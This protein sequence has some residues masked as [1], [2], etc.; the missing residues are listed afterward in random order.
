MKRILAISAVVLGA[1]GAAHAG[2][3]TLN[4]G[5]TNNTGN[6]GLIGVGS[7]GAV[8]NIPGCNGYILGA[9]NTGCTT[10]VPSY[11]TSMGKIN[12]DQFLFQQATLN[13]A[14]PAV[15]TATALSPNTITTSATRLLP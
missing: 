11:F 9:A 14:N 12:Y 6:Y 2:Q 8:G 7:G 10:V 1:F 15:P 4:M 3:V 5:Y 13:G